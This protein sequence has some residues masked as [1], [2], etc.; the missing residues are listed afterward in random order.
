MGVIP[1]ILF[2]LVLIVA[3]IVVWTTSAPLP[4]TVATHF[5]RGGYANGFMSHDAY[6]VFMLGMSTLVPLIVV[7]ATG[8][9]PRLVTSQIKIR[10]REFWLAPGRREE[11]LAFITSHG[12]AMGVL[13]AVFLLAM[14]LL[15][16][17]ANERTPPHL[18]GYAFTVVL[19]AFLLLLAVAIG[20]LV[21]RFARMR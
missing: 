5:G 20:A 1:R 12:C 2:V 11:T 21:L 15:V 9:L 7:A 8:L 18:D 16:I 10:H 3:P 4:A 14:H 13:I 17:E 6:V 19:V